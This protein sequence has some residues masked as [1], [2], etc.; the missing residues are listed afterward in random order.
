MHKHPEYYVHRNIHLRHVALPRSL[1]TGGCG[2]GR[3]SGVRPDAHSCQPPEPAVPGTV[4]GGNV[5]GGVPRF[6]SVSRSSPLI[7]GISFFDG[8]DGRI[9]C[10]H[11]AQE[12]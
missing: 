2:N 1:D 5:F 9:N 10:S 11:S 7:P 6:R 3:P 8:P 12:P 4:H